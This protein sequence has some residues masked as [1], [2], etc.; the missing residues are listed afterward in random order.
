M[1][2]TVEGSNS[3]IRL[4]NESVSVKIPPSSLTVCGTLN[5]YPFCALISSSALE[6]VMNQKA[7]VNVKS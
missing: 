5:R 2:K 6:I 3:D 1:W 4:E 7:L